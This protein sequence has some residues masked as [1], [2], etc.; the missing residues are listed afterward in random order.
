[1][2]VNNSTPVLGPILALLKSKEFFAA[3][4]TLIVDMIVS[5]HPAFEG[6]R[7]ELLAVVTTVGLA[8]IGGGLAKDIE[9]AR[10]IPISRLPIFGPL[11]SLLQSRKFLV[12]VGTLV[13]NMAVAQ[14]PSLQ[15]SE[16]AMITVITVIGGVLVGSI[17]YE[18]GK[19]SAAPL[20][21]RG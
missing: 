11:V 9:N 21:L 16:D 8:V 17:A 7:V 14:L 3:V 19:K 15:G 13:A 4:A 2:T 6:M 20:G 10:G 12:S 1:M 5:L 18:D